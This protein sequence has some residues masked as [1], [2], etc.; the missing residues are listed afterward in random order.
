MIDVA[1][2]RCKG[3]I[4]GNAGMAF[5][6]FHNMTNQ[7]ISERAQRPDHEAALISAGESTVRSQSPILIERLGR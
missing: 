1:Y 2:R 5:Q 3:A 7:L 4:D 6:M